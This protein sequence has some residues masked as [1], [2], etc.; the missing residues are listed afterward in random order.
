MK[1]KYQLVACILRIPE[2][3]QKYRYPK[4]SQ[5]LEAGQF[6]RYVGEIATF[7]WQILIPINIRN[8]KVGLFVISLQYLKI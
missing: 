4:I 8:L 5:L 6:C 2:K 3:H 7:G 1:T